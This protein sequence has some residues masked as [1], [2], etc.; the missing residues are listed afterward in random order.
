MFC[1][2]R[3]I[4]RSLIAA[5]LLLPMLSYGQISLDAEFR[6]RAEF[7]HGYK[8]LKTAEDDPAFFVSQRARLNFEFTKDAYTFK[9]S[10]QDV[11]TWGEVGQLDDSPNTNIHEVWAKINLGKGF[12]VKLGRQELIY[13]DQRLLGSV[14]WAQQARS[15][16]A[17]LVKYKDTSANFSIDLAGAYN[18]DE[19]KVLNNTYSRDNYKVMSFVHA[20]KDFGNFG[21]SL[22][23][24]TDGFETEK[25]EVNY[26]YTYGTHLD[27]SFNNWYF[28]G[29]FY[30]QNGDD[31]GRENISAFMASATAR[32]N[33]KH[34]SLKLGYDYL[35]GGD[36]NDA[37]PKRQTFNTLYAT[38]HKF[39][40]NMDYFTS[41]PGDTGG[42]G[43][44]D[45][46]LKTDFSF[47]THLGL[48]F[49]YHYF[50]LANS[51]KIP[52]VPK[53]NLDKSLASEFD[54]SMRYTPMEDLSLKL[55]YSALF[56]DN[57]LE[58]TQG[59]RADGLQQ[60]AWAMLV[61]KPQ[62]IN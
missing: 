13:D 31:A 40:G 54:L 55:G 28:T 21:A 43:L 26:R 51:L 27:Y 58:K 39:Y 2:H 38:N 33:F 36:R 46:Y 9:L 56:S 23:A 5:F 45:I 7:R 14:N 22:I 6:P 15:H 50:A 60:W 59:R 62:F 35:S 10:G 4:M 17:L 47:N 16:D 53:Q 12:R 57:A 11:R 20:H 1:E 19:Q 61:L 37:N 44:N 41:I 30:A 34:A 29:S 52:A 32:Y 24:L 49:S 42:G 48:N 18:Q 3:K 8:T 25:D